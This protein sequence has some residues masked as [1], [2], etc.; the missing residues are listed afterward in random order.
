[1]VSRSEVFH[2]VRVKNKLLH[3]NWTNEVRSVNSRRLQWTGRDMHA[4][5]WLPCVHRKHTWITNTLETHLFGE[6]SCIH[7][8]YTLDR[9]IITCYYALHGILSYVGSS[10][11]SV[12]FHEIQV[13]VFF[14]LRRLCSHWTRWRMNLTALWTWTRQISKDQVLIV[15]S[16]SIPAKI[17]DIIHSV[18]MRVQ[19]LLAQCLTLRY[20]MCH[21]CISVSTIVPTVIQTVQQVLGHYVLYMLGTYIIHSKELIPHIARL[22]SICFC[23]PR[24]NP[25]FSQLI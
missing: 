16:Q 3:N 24:S 6:L 1:M 5:P 13:V 18:P 9:H 4:I 10:H 12:Y 8:A 25:N 7:L 17:P 15:K 14:S 19:T 21:R 23:K 2:L 20:L 11:M 22:H